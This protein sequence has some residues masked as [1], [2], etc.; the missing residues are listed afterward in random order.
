MQSKTFH[1]NVM[2]CYKIW[3][4]PKSFFWELYCQILLKVLIKVGLNFVHLALTKVSKIKKRVNL[5]PIK[6]FFYQGWH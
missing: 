5:G 6:S 4:S 2:K 3:L 1:T